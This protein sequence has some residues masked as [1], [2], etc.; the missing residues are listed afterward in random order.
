[1]ILTKINKKNLT[2]IISEQEQ[3]TAIVNNHI[4]KSDVHQAIYFDNKLLGIKPID[5][6]EEEQEQVFVIDYNILYEA[7]EE[8]FEELGVGD[9]EII[10]STKNKSY[11]IYFRGNLKLDNKF[12]YS[13]SVINHSAKTKDIEF[14]PAIVITNGYDYN[15]I[16]TIYL[17]AIPQSGL[18]NGFIVLNWVK[19]NK[20]IIS[21]LKEATN[22]NDKLEI[23]KDFFKTGISNEF[24]DEFKKFENNKNELKKNQ[25]STKELNA[26]AFD[27]YDKNRNIETLKSDTN[28]SRELKL[29]HKHCDIY[30]NYK[31]TL[32]SLLLFI[33]KNSINFGLNESKLHIFEDALHK[34][35]ALTNLIARTLEGKNKDEKELRK[36]ISEQV[37]ALNNILFLID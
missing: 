34:K 10:Y 1:M 24:K 6:D 9:E 33:G 22:R 20:S 17:L 37:K 28:K 12:E 21:E 18:H 25:V 30:F 2:E 19:I 36:Y 7:A 14:E 27:I 5:R 15:D 29:F 13:K 8:M 16:T 35:K 32:H 31:E 4:V 3:L 26:I 23:L 11:A